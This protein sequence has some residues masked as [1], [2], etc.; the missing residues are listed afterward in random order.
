MDTAKRLYEALFLVDSAL[1]AGDWAGLV[2]KITEMIEKRS[3]EIVSLKKWDE[4]RLAY[5]I[6]DKTRGTYILVYFNAEP[7]QITKLERDINLSEDVM[8]ALILRADFVD[9][10]QPIDKETPIEA[11]ERLEREV[12]AK[13]EIES[14]LTNEES[15]DSDSEEESD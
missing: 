12:V 2:E 7:D 8:R 5:E 6:N 15:D 1:A 9:Q 10:S 13:A 14:N 11:A 3:G 4:R